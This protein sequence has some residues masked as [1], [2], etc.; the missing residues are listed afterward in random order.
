[1]CV[2]VFLKVPVPD[3][4]MPNS[5]LLPAAA[6]EKSDCDTSASLI[7]EGSGKYS[8]MPING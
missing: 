7:A 6:S 3:M 1:M 4:M 8:G 2:C 5:M